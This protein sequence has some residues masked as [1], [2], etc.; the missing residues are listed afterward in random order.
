MYIK[1]YL[2]RPKRS[3]FALK[4]WVSIIQLMIQVA[5]FIIYP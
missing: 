1:K 4:A 3:S 2:E 5:T